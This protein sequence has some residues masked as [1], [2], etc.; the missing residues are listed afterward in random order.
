MKSSQGQRAARG[1][2]GD[3]KA[4]AEQQR[5]RDERRV[6]EDAEWITARERWSGD[7][8][9]TER[10]G[11]QCGGE[12][13]GGGAGAASAGSS[14]MHSASVIREERGEGSE[15]G[16]DT[17]GWEGERVVR[18]EEGIRVE[19]WR[20]R[21]RGKRKVDDQVVVAPGAY[22]SSRKMPKGSKVIRWTAVGRD[23]Y[24]ARQRRYERG[25]GGGVT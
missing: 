13:D 5:R 2:S 3:G 18:R 23:A 12:G 25:E 6:H 24:M 20:E 8:Q 16:K 7:G 22:Q 10:I 21:R 9:R 15:G 11:M 19:E 1:A 17:E 4:N 14:V